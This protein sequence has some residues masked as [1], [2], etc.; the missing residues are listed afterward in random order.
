MNNAHAI[1]NYFIEKAIQENKPIDQMKVQKLVYFAHGWH[2]AM[3]DQPLLTEAIEAWRFGPVIPSLYHALKYSGNKNITKLVKLHDGELIQRIESNQTELR[4]FL[5]KVWSLYSEFS[6][7][8]LSNMTHENG[9]PWAR[10]AHEFKHHIPLNKIL[11]NELIREFF[12]TQKE[13][14]TQSL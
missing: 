7:I 10:V 11:D 14:A 12:Y 2:L 9:T 13:L 5:D 1:A 6:G 8:E 4:L 3:T